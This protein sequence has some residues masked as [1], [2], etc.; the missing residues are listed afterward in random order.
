MTA[1]AVFSFQILMTITGL[2]DRCHQEIIFFVPFFLVLCILKLSHFHG[3]FK[4][5][6]YAEFVVKVLE[7]YFYHTIA[8]C[9]GTVE[10]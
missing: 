6:F 10:I 7:K 9:I 2:V 3:F 8:D 5:M 4:R 1:T